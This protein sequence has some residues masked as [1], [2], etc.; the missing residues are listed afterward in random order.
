M[1]NDKSMEGLCLEGPI[2]MQ[3]E[4]ITYLEQLRKFQQKTP[5]DIKRRIANT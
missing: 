4:N 5:R 3:V 1:T 2:L